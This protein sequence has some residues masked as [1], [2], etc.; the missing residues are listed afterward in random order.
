MRGFEA[1]T[2][3]QPAMVTGFR[4]TAGRVGGPV[5]FMQFRGATERITFS[6]GWREA[7]FILLT[8]TG[9]GSLPV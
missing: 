8:L 2:V 3:C 4:E 7:H 9:R 6:S 5:V 1:A